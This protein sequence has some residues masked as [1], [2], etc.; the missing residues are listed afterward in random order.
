MKIVILA[1]FNSTFGGGDFSVYKYFEYLS[2][3][4]HEVVCFYTSYPEFFESYDKFTCKKKIY[5]N[6]K[7]KG[8]GRLNATIEKIYDKF[9]LNNYLEKHSNEIDFIV[10]YQT[11]TAIKAFNLGRK[12]NIK[13]ANIIFE[14]PLWLEKQWN[15]WSEIWRSSK[16]LRS[17]WQNFKTSLQK[18]DIII[19]IS[20]MTA[21]ETKKWCGREVE[22]VVYPGF[23]IPDRI[24]N[25][26]IPKENQIIFV[27]RLVNNKNVADILK[28]LKLI[29][30][31]PKLVICG[32]G[33]EY[34]NLVSLSNKLNLRCDFMGKVDEEKKWLEIKKSLFMVFPS[35]F[36]GF[37]M[38]P[39]E[40]LAVGTP[41]ICSNIP[42]LCELYGEYVDYVEVHD[43][44]MMAE[45]IKLLATDKNYREMSASRGKNYIGENFGWE[46]A[47]SQIE[48]ILTQFPTK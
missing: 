41:C 35:S 29:E 17:K 20:Q 37:G 8:I 11:D 32:N 38:P 34:H 31:P 42:I 7:F 12:Y 48:T 9:L 26:E 44:K 3:R 46:R 30:N 22:G 27:G 28:A 43:I 6:Y 13:V 24:K 45:K 16:A 1:D 23:I 25:I 47:A 14:T 21:K 2:L 33:D 10:G 4:G 15:A 5:I 19:A 36:E 18:S 40:A 39:M